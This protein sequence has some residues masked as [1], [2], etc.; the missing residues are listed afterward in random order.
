[1][2]AAPPN[3]H[4]PR[5]RLSAGLALLLLAFSQLACRA[6][7]DEY[8]A[9]SEITAI[10][11]LRHLNSALYEYAS[12]NPKE[13][14]PTRLLALPSI[15]PSLIPD[16]LRGRAV[17]GYVYSYVAGPPDSKGVISTYTLQARPDV[18]GETGHRS[19]FTDDSGG[20]RFTL[21]DRAATAR[22]PVVE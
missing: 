14:F 10:G 11:R 7:R 15:D 16:L 13:G 3:L 12:R 17:R 19:F 21:D 18:Y 20:I 4:S 2:S 22:D 8:R 9:A 5:R 6:S 1:M